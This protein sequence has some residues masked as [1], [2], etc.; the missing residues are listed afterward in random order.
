MSTAETI[1]WGT[2]AQKYDI[3]FD[4]NPFYK[5]LHKEV[6]Q[7]VRKWTVAPGDIL[8]DIGAGTGNYSLAMAHSFPMATVLHI[9]KDEGMNARATQKKADG[10]LQNHQI[11]SFGVNEL[12]LE[13]ASLRG[14][15]SIH[16]L[17]TFSDPA[18]VLRDM[19]RWLEPGGEAVLV[20]AGRIVNVLDWQ[21]AIG[22]HLLRKYGLKKMLE[23]MKEGKEVSRQNAYI[24]DLQKQGAYWTHTHDEFCR[25]VRAAGFEILSNKTCF[26]GVSDFVVARKN[27]T[28]KL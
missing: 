6:M 19:C 10:Y 27:T 25:A 15:I 8:A 22:W 20:N 4:H 24:R 13:S 3:L 2:Y 7:E 12:E 26:R 18:K 5:K 17:Y 21:L 14:L 9:D 28:E 23:I 16:A 11:L 1:S